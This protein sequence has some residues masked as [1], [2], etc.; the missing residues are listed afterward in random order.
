MS[1]C[2]F[3]LRLLAVWSMAFWLGG[4][5]FYSAVVIPVLHDQLGSTFE[6]GLVTQ[7]VTNALNLL[8]VTTIVLGWLMTVSQKPSSRSAPG[9]PRL[10]VAA[11]AI[12]T[13]ALVVLIALHP[14]L[15][16]R[17]GTGQ[18]RGFYPLHRLYLWVSTV[19]WIVNL[20]LLACW[21]RL[22]CHRSFKTG[23]ENPQVFRDLRMPEFPT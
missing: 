1:L 21:S 5:T 19:Q 20:C 22:G 12:T 14:A 8:G 17:L 9:R 23:G 15:D 6:T 11:L 7:R 16:Q 3:L 10:P 4:F 18:M 2:T 13:L